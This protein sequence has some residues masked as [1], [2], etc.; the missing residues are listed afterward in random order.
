MRRVQRRTL[1]QDERVREAYT[2]APNDYGLA[3]YADLGTRAQARNSRKRM[4]LPSLARAHRPRNQKEHDA[5]RR[6]LVEHPEWSSAQHAEARGIRPSAWRQ[7]RWR[8]A[9][10][11]LTTPPT[12]AHAASWGQLV[13]QAL[14]AGYLPSRRTRLL[15]W[16]RRPP[17]V[18]LLR[19][20]M[21]PP[22]LAWI[23]PPTAPPVLLRAD[24]AAELAHLATHGLSAALEEPDTDAG[25]MPA[26]VI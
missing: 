17:V 23:A 3:I 1:R 25:A 8:E 6:Q 5:R 24:L 2:R 11:P 12:E 21:L 20:A 4:G 22:R 13:E 19:L 18:F 16:R 10:K 7:W 15:W 26:S 14:R 9:H